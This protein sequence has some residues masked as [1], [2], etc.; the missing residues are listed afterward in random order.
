MEEDNL[1]SDRVGGSETLEFDMIH[2]DNYTNPIS[3]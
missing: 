2:K 1:T 3:S